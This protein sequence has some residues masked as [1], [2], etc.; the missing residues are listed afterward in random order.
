ML[1]AQCHSENSETAR[2]CN[3]CGS[4]LAQSASPDKAPGSALTPRA[5]K[6]LDAPLPFA[7]FRQ[8]A[9][10]TDPASLPTEGPAQPK[11]AS[12][13]TGPR[14][15][16]VKSVPSSKPARVPVPTPYPTLSIWQWALAIGSTAVF[17]ITSSLAIAIALFLLKNSDKVSGLSSQFIVEMALS[18]AAC[19]G[20]ALA[21]P[22]AKTSITVI[23]G[24]VLLQSLTALLSRSTTRFEWLC[25]GALAGSIL[26][27]IWLQ[28]VRQGGDADRISLALTVLAAA[29]ALSA[30][31]AFAVHPA[32]AHGRD[33]ATVAVV[34]GGLLFLRIWLPGAVAR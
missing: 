2:Y 18:G 4:A 11:P 16:Y 8:T 17:L 25:V 14:P 24:G 10:Q 26:M 20:I 31:G 19:C 5:A 7:E 13:S 33:L 6:E 28:G 34:I 27:W 9:I 3:A 21:L 15:L 23:A 22:D 32:F 1:C 30:A 12:V 29:K